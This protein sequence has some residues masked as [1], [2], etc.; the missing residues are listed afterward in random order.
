MISD[1]GFPPTGKK[2]EEL[3]DML[4]VCFRAGV[5]P[6]GMRYHPEH[7]LMLSLPE[8]NKLKKL[9]PDKDLA[10]RYFAELNMRF[11]GETKGSA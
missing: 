4:E 6:K 9:A 11:G 7:G 2:L 8:V 10:E 1:K 5:D 3:N